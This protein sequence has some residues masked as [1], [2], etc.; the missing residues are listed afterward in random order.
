[1]VVAV[2]LGE[3]RAQR[4]VGESG[5]QRGRL[6][7]TALALDEPAGNLA[8]GVHLFLVVHGKRQEVHSLP[9]RA[10]ADGGGQN[11]RLAVAGQHSAVGEPGDAP[12]FERDLAAA[13]LSFAF[14]DHAYSSLG[15]RREPGGP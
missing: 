2:F 12:G 3:Q 13:K 14:Y 10:I 11:D 4:A 5:G 7:R 9:R 6:A 8:G 15:R 1:D